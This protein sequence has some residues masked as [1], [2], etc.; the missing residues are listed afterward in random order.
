MT[1]RL[2]VPGPVPVE[3]EV[4]HQL[5]RPVQVHYGAEWTRIHNETLDMLKQVYKTKG[6]I[7]LLVGSGTAALDAG[8]GSITSPGEKVIVGRNGFFGM[9]LEQICQSYGLEVVRI[10]EALGQRLRPEPFREA[11]EQNPDAVFVALVHLETSTAVLNPL[12]EIAEIAKS[13]DMPVVVDAVSS[14][15]GVELETDAWG[16]DLCAAATQKCLGAPPGLGPIAISDRA[17]RIIESKPERN[18]GWYLNLQTWK[19]YAE[20]WSDWHPFP[21]TMSTN[22]VLALRAGLQ[23]L[24]EE[25]LEARLQRYTDLA[26]RLR[27]GVRELGLRPFTPDDELAPVLTAI[28]GPEGVDTGEI[29][30]Y[31]FDEHQIRVSIGLGEGLKGRIFRVGHMS[32]TTS[33]EDIDAVLTG[34]AAFL[35]SRS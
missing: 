23:S 31:L 16:I 14:L 6:D 34:L 12:R 28:Y 9:R 32:P 35:E 20:D 13:F 33:E 18:H 15:G 5:G 11:L 29:V 19:Q 10:E 17:W 4:L 3:D 7:H 24:L 22:S 26:M 1:H 27:D 25:G 21:V 30:Q 8:I 2:M